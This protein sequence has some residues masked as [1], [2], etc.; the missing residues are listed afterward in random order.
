MKKQS[1]VLLIILCC[2]Y[3]ASSSRP[4][5]RPYLLRR[6]DHSVPD[7]SLYIHC[8]SAPH[9]PHSPISFQLDPTAF[10][11]VIFGPLNYCL[12]FLYCLGPTRVHDRRKN[13]NTVKMNY[14]TTYLQKLNRKQKSTRKKKKLC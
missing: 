9:I 12:V 1:K 3:R 6:T 2:I 13:L 8:I 10:S 5:P 14:G 7:L 11:S 4:S